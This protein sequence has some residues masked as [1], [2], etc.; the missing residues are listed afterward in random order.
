MGKRLHQA[1]KLIS[2]IVTE[3]ISHAKRNSFKLLFIRLCLHVQC[4]FLYNNTDSFICECRQLSNKNHSYISIGSPSFPSFVRG[5]QT[6]RYIPVVLSLANCGRIKQILQ[7]WWIKRAKNSIEHR[8]STISVSVKRDITI[9][10]GKLSKS[11]LGVLS[12]IRPYP[13]SR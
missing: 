6:K 12:L 1:N 13:I 5:S 2:W 7:E 4:E 3:C 10:N 11:L 8:P 9:E